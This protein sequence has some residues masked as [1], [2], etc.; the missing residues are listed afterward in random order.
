[1]KPIIVEVERRSRSSRLRYSTVQGHGWCMTGATLTPA[2][3]LPPLHPCV[4]A[5]PR[6]RLDNPSA[7]CSFGYEYE[8]E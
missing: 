2:T 6:P 7:S 5:R 8:H 3:S 4:F 1:M